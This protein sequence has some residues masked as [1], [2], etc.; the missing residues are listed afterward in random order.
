M[1]LRINSTSAASSTGYTSGTKRKRN[2]KTDQ[3]DRESPLVDEAG[4]MPQGLTEDQELRLSMRQD[5]EDGQQYVE[6]WEKDGAQH[7]KGAWETLKG[8]GAGFGK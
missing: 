1:A 5:L 2:G 4:I 8:A 6:T 7:S 3:V